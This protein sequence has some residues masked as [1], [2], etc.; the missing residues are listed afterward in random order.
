MA[1]QQRRKRGPYRLSDEERQNRRDRM[2]AQRAAGV[3]KPL[4]RMTKQEL[5]AHIEAQLEALSPE[6]RSRAML[7]VER[8]VEQ[9]LDVKATSG[10]V[11]G[12][13]DAVSQV[14]AGGDGEQPSSEPASSPNTAP[15][16]PPHST[17]D[18]NPHDV[19]TDL[20]RAL[21]K[22]ARNINSNL[23]TY[24]EAH[25]GSNGE[26]AEPGYDDS[27]DAQTTRAFLG[28]RSPEPESRPHT[29]YQVLQAERRRLLP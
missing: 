25:P 18:P 26:A 5:N 16:S 24:R 11:N 20:D 22:L 4:S 8:M 3:M 19:E 14:Q 23:G 12:E 10:N 29:T 15:H 21:A 13:V 9:E 27:D 17:T 2:N 28:P 1:K 6:D 7:E